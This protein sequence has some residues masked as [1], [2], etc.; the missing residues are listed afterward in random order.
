MKR[1]YL[2]LL[3]AVSFFTNRIAKKDPGG[4]KA[5]SPGSNEPCERT[6]GVSAKIAQLHPS[7]PPGRIFPYPS[8]EM[9]LRRDGWSI[10][11]WVDT[12]GVRSQGS[13]DPGLMAG[14]PPV[15]KVPNAL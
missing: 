13:L 12:P 14:T 8:A 6:P 10:R 7:R 1:H 11:C 2:P 15:S 3:I 9:R 4:V 5:I